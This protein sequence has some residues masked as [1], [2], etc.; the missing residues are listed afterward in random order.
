MVKI[1]EL[2]EVIGRTGIKKP[3]QLL[4]AAFTLTSII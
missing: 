3:P 4:E 2:Q 1:V